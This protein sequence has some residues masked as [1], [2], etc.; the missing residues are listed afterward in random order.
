MAN[1]PTKT[2]T[3]K[4]GRPAKSNSMDASLTIKLPSDLREA[5]N[6]KSQTTGTPVAFVVRK[7]LEAW[8][9]ER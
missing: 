4:R 1:Q 7:A 5:A 6:E 3:T 2:K 8:V 9:G